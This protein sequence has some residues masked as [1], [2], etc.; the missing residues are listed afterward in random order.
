MIY[1]K[2]DE[3]LYPATITGTTRDLEWGDRESKSIRLEGTYEMVNALFTDGVSWSIVMEELADVT[4]Q[5]VTDEEGNPVYEQI[6]VTPKFN[7]DPETGDIL[8]DEEGHPIPYDGE[9][10]YKDGALIEYNGEPIYELQLVG[11]DNSEYSIRGDLSV[12]TDG[13]CTVK[14]GKPTELEVLKLNS[15]SQEAQV[16]EMSAKNEELQTALDILLG[17]NV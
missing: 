8:Y 16:A 12:H 4:P 7:T 9:P 13:T 14:M 15:S 6:D 11:Y 3:T 5:F 1:V 17:G 10:V 2:I